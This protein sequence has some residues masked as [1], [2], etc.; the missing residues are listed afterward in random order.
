MKSRVISQG[1]RETL[2]NALTTLALRDEFAAIRAILN[3]A[4]DEILPLYNTF[5]DEIMDASPI[6]QQFVGAKEHD[7]IDMSKDTRFSLRWI[8][9]TIAPY[10]HTPE[11]VLEDM[12]TNFPTPPWEID[13][14]PDWLSEIYEA[15]KFGWGRFPYFNLRDLRVASN[16]A[17]IGSGYRVSCAPLTDSQMEELRPAMETLA[18]ANVKGESIRNSYIDLRQE[19]DFNIEKARTTKNLVAAWPETEHF[20]ERLYPSGDGSDVE[21]PL[22]S[23]V[24]RHVSQ[25]PSPEAA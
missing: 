12:G 16:R 1:N 5:M 18:S 9:D 19:I 20:I 8:R 13:K 24:L 11:L 25:L 23:I 15:N 6:V 22:G 14:D 3:K 10:I 2:S 7:D 4:S 21:T 17:I